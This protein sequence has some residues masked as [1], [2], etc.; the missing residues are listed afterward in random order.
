MRVFLHVGKHYAQLMILLMFVQ[1]CSSVTVTPVPIGTPIPSPLPPDFSILPLFTPA[2]PCE[3]ENT[4]AEDENLC[5]YEGVQEMAIGEGEHSV[6]IQRDYHI[7]QGCWSSI[8]V[9]TH[10][11]RVCD[12]RSGQGTALTTHLASSVVRSPDGAWFAFDTFEW[13]IQPEKGALPRIHIYRVRLDGTGLQMLDTQG[14][15]NGTVGAQL[16][17]WSPDGAWLAFQFW[18]GTENGWHDYRVKADGSGLYERDSITVAST[19][20][21]VSDYTTEAQTPL[22][23]CAERSCTVVSTA[24][25]GVSLPI[26]VRHDAGSDYWLEVEYIGWRLFVGPFIQ[27]SITYAYPP[28]AARSCSSRQCPVRLTIPGTEDILSLDVVVTNLVEYWTHTVYQGEELYL[29]PWIPPPSNDVWM[30]TVM[31]ASETA[32][33]QGTYAA[34]LPAP[35]LSLDVSA[36]VTLAPSYTPSVTRLP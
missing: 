18:D 7:G 35:L 8:N 29:G 12:R 9:D 16:A 34:T 1:A 10:E 6:L 13:D 32:R 3:L 5:R 24:P 14:L 30:T 11:L 33:A 20:Q 19:S 4:S 22:R 21:P 28:G 36:T 2:Y 25:R 23:E 31:P 26:V 27:V 17:G 15:P